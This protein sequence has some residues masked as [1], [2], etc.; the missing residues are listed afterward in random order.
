[1]ENIKAYFYILLDTHAIY[2]KFL[3]REFKKIFETET[4]IILFWN[5]KTLCDIEVLSYWVWIR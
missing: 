3:P 1:M 5:R 2:S 4:I